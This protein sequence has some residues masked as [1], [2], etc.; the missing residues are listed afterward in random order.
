MAPFAGWLMPIHYSN[1]GALA[2]HLHTREHASIFDVSHMLQISFTGKDRVKFIES[3]VVG[4]IGDL[5]AG[6]GSLSLL[7]N[8]NGGIIDDTIITN[9]GEA[10]YM[11]SNAACAESD[12]AH[13][14]KHLE[15]FQKNGCE[16][17][18]QI[19]NDHSLVALQGP[20]S[21]KVLESLT[22]KSLSDMPFMNARWMDIAG[23]KC[24]VARSGYTGEDG[25]ELSTPS[26]EVVDITRRLVDLYEVEFA[27]L[28]AGV[29]LRFE[30]GLFLYGFYIDATTTPM[31]ANLVWTVGKRRRQEGGFFGR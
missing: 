6:V 19:I 17:E 26:S 8:E 15:A 7:T 1:M 12:L 2:S 22:G 4:D 3:L 24:H 14:R 21:A 25:F 5:P 30:A 16:V 29:W 13:I 27:G 10:I 28:G 23:V 20:D 9:Q 31:E 18:L 11:V